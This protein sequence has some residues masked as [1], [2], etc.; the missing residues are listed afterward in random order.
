MA[1]SDFDVR[2]K[3]ARELESQWLVCRSRACLYDGSTLDGPLTMLWL[4]RTALLAVV[5][6]GA[7][8]ALVFT[9]QRS[10]QYFPLTARVAAA[11]LGLTGFSDLTL[12]TSDGESIVAWWKPPE[13]GRAVLVYFH[14]NGGSLWHR[15]DRAR[16][17]TGDGRGLLLVSY[18]GYSG[19]TGAPSEEGLRLDAQAAYGFVAQRYEPARIVLYG[20]SLG[21]GV[22][23]R[24]AA[25]RAVGGLILDAPFTSAVDVA[26]RHYWFLPVDWL[27]RDQFR[28]LDR[29]GGLKSPI[30]VLHGDRD[31][32]IPVELGE[33]LYAAAPEP[34]RFVRLPGVG[35]AEV[36]EQGG[37]AS[38]RSFLTEVEARFAA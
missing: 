2:L 19:S 35:H 21:T 9:F 20:E 8:L 16:R 36:L 11:E 25:E 14:G 15:Q 17:L 12:R 5:L 27:M 23:V 37:L 6:Y 1:H 3:Y 32:I 13:P 31:G 22:A 30:L 33:Q 26:R 29:I 4:L 28:S 7:L 24:L 18:R 10:L 38:V 34:K